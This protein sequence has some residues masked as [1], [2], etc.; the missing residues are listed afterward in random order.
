MLENI[1]RIG[2][3]EKTEP[4]YAPTVIVPS[5][6]FEPFSVSVR[7]TRHPTF[8]EKF[9]DFPSLGVS[10]R[11]RGGSSRI[12]TETDSVKNRLFLTWVLKK[13][14]SKQ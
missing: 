4:Q 12:T 14:V 6:I 13:R 10:D 8:P 9:S 3:I 2:N 11:R 1:E 7:L 5:P